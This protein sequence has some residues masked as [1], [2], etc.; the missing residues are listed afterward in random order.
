MCSSDLERQGR[1][2]Y[3]S[4]AVHQDAVV[5]DDAIEKMVFYLM[6]AKGA[7]GMHLLLCIRIQLYW[8]MQLRRWCSIS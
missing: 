1:S 2:R 6:N 3:A 4:A 5:L 8:M 7:A